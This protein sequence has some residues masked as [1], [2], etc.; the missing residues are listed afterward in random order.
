LQ[1]KASQKAGDRFPRL[2][3]D[4]DDARLYRVRLVAGEALREAEDHF[5]RLEEPSIFGAAREQVYQDNA[6]LLTSLQLKL[7][8]QLKIVSLI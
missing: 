8:E 3:L 6:Q 4:Q 5:S 7:S 1:E 2:E